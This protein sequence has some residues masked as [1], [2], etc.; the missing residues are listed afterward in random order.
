[1]FG[2]SGLMF[3]LLQLQLLQFLP[4]DGVLDF[5]LFGGGNHG[6]VFF[7]MSLFFFL[8]FCR[9]VGRSARKNDLFFLHS[10]GHDTCRQ[11]GITELSLMSFQPNHF[12]KLLLLNQ[13]I[14][15]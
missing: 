11:V 14:L 7:A 10:D 13:S 12:Q 2:G 15:I 3:L 8:S 5:L 6:F 9:Q 4:G 1:M